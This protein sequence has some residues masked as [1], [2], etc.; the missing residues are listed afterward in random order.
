MRTAAAQPLF[1]SSRHWATPAP[2]RRSQ[3]LRRSH[4][5]TLVEL[6]VSITLGLVIL[7]ALLA[8][9]GN[10][11]RSNNEM[12]KTNQLIENGRFAMQLLQDDVAHAGFW[13]PVRMIN[14]TAVPN[15]CLAY[16]SWPTDAA[17]LDAYKKNLLAIPVHGYADGSALSACGPGLANVVAQS[18]VLIVR[19]AST[20]VKGP[21]CDTADT[22][23]HIQVSGCRTDAPPEPAHVLETP[24][25]MDA[26]TPRIRLKNCATEAARRKMV[27]NAYYVANSATGIPTL[28]RVRMANGTFL[29]AEP[30]VDGIQAFKV[31]FGVDDKGS[32]GLPISSTNPGDGNADTYVS[33]APS[34]D[35][36][37]LANV[38]S[39]KLHLLV[40]NLEPTAGHTDDKAYQVGPLAVA[41]AN[42]N[43]KRHVFTTTVR[44]V[45]PSS[46]R[47]IP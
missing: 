47:E 2:K 24:A 30:L 46:R 37:V 6:L 29:A 45:N 23:P 1:Q 11:T 34:C 32:N 43:I 14:A 21:G 9:F 38:V 4:G 17:E 10:V 12:A 27:I 13:G 39:V 16:A 20:C 19:H 5:L 33:C 31:E 22:G 8:L 40:R 26:R 28:M 36:A 44:M 42:D 35:L 25:E 18:D 41:A 15:P 7:T 3:R